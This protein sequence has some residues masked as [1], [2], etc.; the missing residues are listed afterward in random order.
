VR[1][2]IPR[3]ERW[4]WQTFGITWLVYASYYF[5]RQSFSVAK[6]ALEKGPVHLTRQDL[7]L[8]DAAYLTTYSFGQ[9]F[10]GPLADRFGPRRILLFGMG[11]SVLAAIGSGFSTVLV[12]FLTF[13]VLQ[14]VAQST[15]WT[16]TS[17]AM[18]SW[19]SLQERGR[20]IGWW[21]THY[22]VGAAVASPFAGWLMDAF[23]RVTTN[24]LGKTEVVPFWPA[25]FWGPAAVVA[26]VMVLTWLLLRNRP[27]DVGLPPIEQYQQDPEATV[28]ESYTQA[29]PALA[30]EGSWT[31]IGEVLATPSVWLLALSYFPVKLARYSLYFWGPKFVE[32][33]L[34]TGAFTSA[35]TA[36]WM[37]IGGMIGIIA[38]GYISD[39][40]FQ[41][42]RAPVCVISLLAAAGVMAA[43]LLKIDNLWLM[44][45]YFFMVGV[46]LYGPDSMISATA[47][48]DFG[49]KRGAGAATGLIN[50]IGSFGAVLGGYLPGVLTSESDWSPLFAISLF[51]LAISAIVLMPLWRTRPPAA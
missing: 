18:S 3:Y 15:G 24:S 49:T 19:F 11:L 27:E 25:A 16:A 51:G 5:T 17:K 28:G 20:V 7:G 41:A 36:A 33:S 47:A 43:G 26:V 39:K 21:C 40:K 35:M 22:T 14:G 44:R 4:R 10:F 2:L 8:V 38:S 30:A 37:P 45:A 29:T 1:A 12:A 32:E 48:I 34:S 6:V 50:G 31:T 42:R 13:A 23:G 9:L 46:F